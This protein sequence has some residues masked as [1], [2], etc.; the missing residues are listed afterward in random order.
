[1]PMKGSEKAKEPR[2]RAGSHHENREDKP[3][4]TTGQ[5]GRRTSPPANA[6][7]ALQGLD[8]ADT[9]GKALRRANR[10]DL[11][12][13]DGAHRHRSEAPDRTRH[14]PGDHRPQG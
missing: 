8:R 5:T 4:E 10:L 11:A 3:Q 9:Q 1:M 14:F 12:L 6:L 13:L 2:P 7:R